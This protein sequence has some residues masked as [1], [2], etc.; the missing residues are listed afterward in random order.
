LAVLLSLAGQEHLARAQ[1]KSVGG[2]VG[3]GFPLVTHDGVVVTTLG[4]FFQV[5]LP[6]AITVSGFGRM[7]FDIEFVP[8]IV[9]R[10]REIRLTV[11]PGILWRLGHGFAAGSRIGFDVNSPQF[12]ITPLVVKSF[13]IEHSFFTAYFVETDFVFRFSRPISGP[14]TNPFTFN[15]VFGLAF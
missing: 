3:V 1:E 13:P 11:N 9:D 8:L 15:M 10:P 2:H 5:S 7:Y 12:G 14:A 6:V 4:D